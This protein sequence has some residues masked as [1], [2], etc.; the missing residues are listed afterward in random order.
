M[1][2]R[3][4]AAHLQCSVATARSYVHQRNYCIT[5]HCQWWKFFSLLK[6]LFTTFLHINE[7]W[8]TWTSLLLED[9]PCMHISS[10]QIWSLKNNSGGF[11]I[12]KGLSCIA[13]VFMPKKSISVHH[14]KVALRCAPIVVCKKACNILTRV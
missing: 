11:M 1:A 8:D 4:V 5:I 14:C 6:R 2:R 7:S 13:P 12:P 10:V 3:T 9:T